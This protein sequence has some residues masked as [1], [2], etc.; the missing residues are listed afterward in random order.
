MSKSTIV[1]GD[2]TLSRCVFTHFS[3][4]YNLP[5]AYYCA[6]D[7]GRVSSAEQNRGPIYSDELG[8][9]IERPRDGYTLRDLWEIN[10]GD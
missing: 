2:R 1:S 5:Q 10:V 8:M 7:L 9:L 4:P 6:G 3:P